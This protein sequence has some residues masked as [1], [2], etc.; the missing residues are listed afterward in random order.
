MIEKTYLCSGKEDGFH[1]YVTL[2]K[3]FV[4]NESIRKLI[5]LLQSGIRNIKWMDNQTIILKDDNKESKNS[6]LHFQINTGRDFTKSKN[7]LKKEGFEQ[8]PATILY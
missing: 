2:E 5:F 3:E 7:I 8:I 4:Y 1:F 6:Y